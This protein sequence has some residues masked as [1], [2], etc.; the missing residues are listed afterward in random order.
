MNKAKISCRRGNKRNQSGQEKERR[1][2]E[3]E[4]SD[5]KKRISSFTVCIPT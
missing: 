3:G 1:A 5:E 4:S 2:E